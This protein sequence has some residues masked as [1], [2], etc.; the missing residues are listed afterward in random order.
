[1]QID[2]LIAMIE[3]RRSKL[4]QFADNERD[5][6]RRILRDQIGRCAGH[7]NKTTALIQFCIEI[8]KEPDPICYLQVS[9]RLSKLKKEWTTENAIM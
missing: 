5:M 8:L 7:L 1:M 4:L 9:R 6:K 3:E 2:A